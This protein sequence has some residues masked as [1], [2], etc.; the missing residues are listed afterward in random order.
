MSVVETHISRFD[1]TNKKLLLA[2]SGGVDS[3]VLF[4]A[5]KSQGIPFA[6]LHVNYHLRGLDSDEDEHFVR[7]LCFDSGIPHR[8]FN[9][10]PALTKKEGRNL[11]NEAR[12][13]RRKLFRQWTAISEKH[14][15]VLAHHEDDQTET[16]FL[17]YFRGSG[18]F[19]LAGMHENKDQLLRPFLGISKETIREYANE[20]SLHWREDKSN[21][22]NTYLRNLFRNILIPALKKEIPGLT[23]SILLFQDQLRI[24][25]NRTETEKAALIDAIVSKAEFTFDEWHELTETGQLLLVRKLD[26]DPWVKVR[27]SQ[28]EVLDLSAEV[29]AGNYAFYKGDDKVYIRRTDGPEKHWEYKILET[30]TGEPESGSVLRCDPVITQQELLVRAPQKKDKIRLKGMTG[31]KSVW[32]LLKSKGIPAQ[33]RSQVPVFECNGEIIWV[34][35]FEVSQ[36]PFVENTGSSTLYV[37]LIEKGK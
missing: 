18:N 20:H 35:G 6:V 3:V 16:F 22:T 26:L 19:G 9:C 27:I 15:V 34:F 37:T 1:F 21:A 10:P 32:E 25:N 12:D 8:V 28:L 33:L 17:Q 2:C 29:L 30:I 31:R 36:S 24:A 7:N 13:F 5:L 4:H 23:E 11:Q 14:Y